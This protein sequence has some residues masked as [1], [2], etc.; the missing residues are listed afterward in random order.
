MI[1]STTETE[2]NKMKYSANNLSGQI[3][4][5]LEDFVKGGQHSHETAMKIALELVKD[6]DTAKQIQAIKDELDA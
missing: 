6:Q 2:Q 3:E 5:L 1:T 4:S